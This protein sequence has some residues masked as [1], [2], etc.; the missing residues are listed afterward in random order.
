MKLHEVPRKSW[1]RVLPDPEVVTKVP[2]SAPMIADGE[3]IFFHHIDGMYSLCRNQGGQICHLVAW[4][5]VEIVG[6]PLKGAQ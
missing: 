4:Q 5:E 1:I 3:V 2:P 6:E